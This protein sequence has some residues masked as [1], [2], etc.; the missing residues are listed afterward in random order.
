MVSPPLAK[1]SSEQL[2]R[3]RC[4]LALGGLR[5]CKCSRYHWY[6]CCSPSQTQAR[7]LTL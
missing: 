3:D 5:R 1:G 4:I 7:R 2:C 6:R